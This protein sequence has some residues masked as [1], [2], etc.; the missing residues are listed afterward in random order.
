MIRPIIEQR[1]TKVS[2]LL[3]AIVRDRQTRSIILIML[4]ATLGF[5]CLSFINMYMH[6]QVHGAINKQYGMDNVYGYDIKGIM[7]RAYTQSIVPA[8][9]TYDE[10]CDSTCKTLHMQNE[11]VSYNLE[12]I[13][14]ILFLIFIMGLLYYHIRWFDIDLFFSHLNDIEEEKWRKK[15]LQRMKAILDQAPMEL[16]N[17]NQD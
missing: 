14:Q 5:M 12:N 16:P 9:H 8:N 4:L 3:R 1:R 10:L 15:E 17:I 2:D 6:E 7:F 11:I 13:G